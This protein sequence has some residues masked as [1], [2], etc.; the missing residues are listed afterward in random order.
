VPGI[1]VAG[2]VADVTAQVTAL[3]VQGLT[4]AGAINVDLLI[5]DTPSPSSRR[6]G[7]EVI[8]ADT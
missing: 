7:A 6:V 1:W 3:A 8:R 5:E 4:V 2:N